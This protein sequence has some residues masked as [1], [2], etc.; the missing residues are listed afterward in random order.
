MRS[1]IIYRRIGNFSKVIG[2]YETIERAKAVFEDIHK[3]YSPV[4]LIT[5]ALSEEQ[6]KQFIGSEN[7]K[8]KVVMMPMDNKDWT[9]STY[10]NIVYYM[11]KE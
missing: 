1:N 11:P 4:G 7:V 3:A 5:C 8:Q 6:A 9:V 10:D 2:E